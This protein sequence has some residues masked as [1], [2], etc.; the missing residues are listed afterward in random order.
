M[1]L[2]INNL[3]WILIGVVVYAGIFTYKVPQTIF[4]WIKDNM[5]EK[6]CYKFLDNEMFNDYIRE[7]PWMATSDKQVPLNHESIGAAL[8]RISIENTKLAKTIT[9]LEQSN[10]ELKTLL[11]GVSKVKI[12]DGQID[13]RTYLIGQ[14]MNGLLSNGLYTYDV[15]ATYAIIAADKALKEISDGRVN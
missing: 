13:V 8:K 2:V 5:W 10:Q 7:L 3:H 4:T 1:S 14:I 9:D 6:M 12:G 15:C 11:N